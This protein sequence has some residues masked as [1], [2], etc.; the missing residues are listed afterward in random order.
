L[1]AGL[2]RIL[3]IAIDDLPEMWLFLK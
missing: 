1:G 2:A 3:D